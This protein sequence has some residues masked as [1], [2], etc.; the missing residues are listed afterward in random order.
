MKPQLIE[1]SNPSN[2]SFSIREHKG[3]DFSY[4]FHF[5]DSYE[6][7]YIVQGKGTRLV[8]NRINT[9]ESGDLVFLG[10]NVP[11]CWRSD[12]KKNGVDDT[13]IIQSIVV[14]FNHD[15]AGQ[16]FFTLSEN[17]LLLKLLNNS[18]TGLNINGE[19]K[20]RCKKK[21][22]QLIKEKK[23]NR[24]IILLEILDLIANSKNNLPISVSNIIGVKKQELDRMNNVINYISDN[25]LNPISLKNISEIANMNKS[26]FCKYFKKRYRKTVFEMINEIRIDHAC[27]LIRE[28]K[29]NI[30]QVCYQSGFNNF[31]NFSRMFKKNINKTPS[32]YANALANKGN[33]KN[34]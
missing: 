8:G 19:A 20:N 29:Y 5:H 25:Y 14:R 12:S 27:R 11:H 22:M 24:L 33:I 7:T 13:S 34:Y 3:S 4:P 6:I 2:C 1:H 18:S 23:C 16:H 21:M 9:F 10:R 26:A 32:E 31:S 17:H 30:T 28:E 15:F